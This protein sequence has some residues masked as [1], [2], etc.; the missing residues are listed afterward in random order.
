MLSA[1]A[2]TCSDEHDVV[3]SVLRLHAVHH[4]L[5]QRVRD[6]G[7]DQHRPPQRRVHRAP[8]ERVAAGE[9][10]HRV[11]EVLGAGELSA[12]LVGDFTGT[13]RKINT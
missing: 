11:R 7:L 1:N 5:P 3:L 12:R 2:L 9:V 10:Q 8:H 13:L 6:V 4:D